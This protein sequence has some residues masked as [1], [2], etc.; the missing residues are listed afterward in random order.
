MNVLHRSHLFARLSRGD[1]P[2][3]NPVVNGH[4]YT[5]SYYL[6]DGIY[7]ARATFVKT[8]QNPQTKKQTQ[9]AKTK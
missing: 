5:M 2:S 7:P 1:S 9:F 4:D 3:S 8:I 6:A